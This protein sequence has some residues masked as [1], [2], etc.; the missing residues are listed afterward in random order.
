MYLSYAEDSPDH[1]DS[2]RRFATFLRA[3]LGVD[4]ELD[5]WYATERRDWVAW[6]VRQLRDADFVL[7]VASPDYKRIADGEPGT[8]SGRTRELEGALI[9]DNLARNVPESTRRVLSVV[10]PGGRAEDVPDCLRPSSTGYHLIAEYTRGALEPLLRVLAGAPLHEKPARGVFMAPAPGVDPVVVVSPPA[11]PV[12]QGVLAVGEDLVLGGVRYLVDGSH[13]AE[14][15]DRDHSVIRRR[16]RASALDPHDGSVWLRQLEMRHHTGVAESAF[17]DLRRERELL[18]A[19]A[20]GTSGLPE[21]LGLFR[22]GPLA[23]LVTRWPSS[24]PVDGPAGTLA[25]AVPAPG[26]RTDPWRM[27]QILRGVAGLCRALAALHARGAAHRNLTPEVIARLDDGR[28]VLLDLGLAGSAPRGGEGPGD[29]RAPEQR[30]GRFPTLGAATDVYQVAA[31]THH[32]VTGFPPAP[33]GAL[34]IGSRVRAV[35]PRAAAALDA[36]LAAE[37]GD[38]PAMNDLASALATLPATAP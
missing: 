23:T 20:G 34:P 24:R 8:S 26:E 16:A 22:D 5:A 10:L 12:R 21:P 2:V 7:A 1:V 30:R 19:L 6:T 37:P 35:P 14:E 4:A 32:L 17:A 38:R 13:W 18:T 25:A 29:Y 31:L 36:S 28:L 33:A 27:W 15:P 11:G 9:R 3:E